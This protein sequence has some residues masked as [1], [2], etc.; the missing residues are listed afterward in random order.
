MMK[1]L[2]Q[3]ARRTTKLPPPEPTPTPTPNR[4][5][6]ASSYLWGDGLE[7]GALHNPLPLPPQARVTYV[8]RMDVIGLRK[9]YPELH[10]VSIVPVDIIDNGETLTSIADAS[11]DF[12]IANH[13]LEHCQ[14]PIG[15][16]KTLLRVLKQDGTL[17]LAVPDKRFTFDVDRPLTT[18]GHLYSDHVHGPEGS[19]RQHYEEWVL[20]VNKPL[21]PVDAQRQLDHVLAIDYSIHFHVW[22][23]STWLEFLHAMQKDLPFEVEVFIK[24]GH[25]MINILR[26][27]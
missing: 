14:D 13:F 25:E 19:R 5:M 1:M 7:I 3:F 21:D 26:K 8:D 4:R 11:Q 6:L 24:S 27:K 23:Q 2:K 18:L 9:H 17:Y 15:T 12:V 22:D 16:L 10:N 20:L